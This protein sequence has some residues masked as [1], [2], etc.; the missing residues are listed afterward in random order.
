MHQKLQDLQF[1]YLACRIEDTFEGLEKGFANHLS[2]L[3]REQITLLF[4][5]GP[6]HRR[7]HKAMADLNHDLAGIKDNVSAVDL[8][9]A[10]RDCELM[11]HDFYA[12]NASKLSEPSL[13]ELFQGMAREETTHVDAAERALALASTEATS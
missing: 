7:L 3:L 9:K 5:E 12:R 2:P 10:I 6:S 1:L 8:L 11:A 13:R 4:Q